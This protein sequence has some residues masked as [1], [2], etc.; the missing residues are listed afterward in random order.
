[1]VIES[2]DATEAVVREGELR[3]M[4]SNCECSF[5]YIEHHMP[6]ENAHGIRELA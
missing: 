2:T 1:M 5:G 3:L 6:V 4:K